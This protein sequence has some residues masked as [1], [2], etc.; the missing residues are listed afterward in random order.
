MQSHGCLER[1]FILPQ[2]FL[3]GL[4]EI[5]MLSLTEPWQADEPMATIIL[6]AL[7]KG[8]SPR[9]KGIRFTARLSWHQQNPN[10]LY[11]SLLFVYHNTCP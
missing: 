5:S 8:K 9:E 10:Q 1:G 2:L 11:F 3:G 7:H 6:G 4:L